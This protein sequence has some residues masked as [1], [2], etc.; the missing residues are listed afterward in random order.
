MFS[1]VESFANK[2]PV[3]FN[4]GLRFNGSIILICLQSIEYSIE[5]LPNDLETIRYEKILCICLYCDNCQNHV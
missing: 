1:K 2:A 3:A 4:R 5:L